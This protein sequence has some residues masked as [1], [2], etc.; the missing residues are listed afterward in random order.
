MPM[1]ALEPLLQQIPDLKIIHLIRDPR[2]TTK[3]QNRFGEIKSKF[4]QRD[5]TMFC[6]RVYKDVLKVKEFNN[7]Y[8]G[9]VKTVFYEDVAGNPIV[10]SRE[11]YQ[12]LGIK[13]TSIAEERIR[14]MTLSGIEKACGI[15]CT[16]RANSSAQ[17]N[18]WRRDITM[19]FVKAVDSSCQ[20]LYSKLGYKQ[21]HT[22]TELR[23]LD[24]KLRCSDLIV[25]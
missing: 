4:L 23:D 10:L 2:A 24:Y 12:F 13:F 5:L 19:N 8:P 22:E 21:V 6:E 15:L 25:T 11:I 7:L 17:V 20:P 18:A 14:N 3:S 1:F 16:H 9:R